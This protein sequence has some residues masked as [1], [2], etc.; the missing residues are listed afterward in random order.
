[1]GQERKRTIARQASTGQ[2]LGTVTQAPGPTGI[3]FTPGANN[4]FP[5]SGVQANSLFFLPLFYND[6]HI[7]EFLDRF[8]RCA[9]SSSRSLRT[10]L[11]AT[12]AEG[13]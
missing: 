1:M 3:T 4:N 13:F 11:L 5:G 9:S 10:R 8:A 12:G 6:T 7:R 2:T